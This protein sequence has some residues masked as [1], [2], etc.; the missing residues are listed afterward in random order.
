MIHNHDRS[1]WFGAS[2]TERVMGRWTGKTFDAWWH[3]KLGEPRK[4]I[5]TAAMRAGNEY[6]PR[7]LDAI[8]VE[9]RDGQILNRDLLLRVNL[10][11][12]DGDTIYEVK[13]VKRE[14]Q[15]VPKRIWMQCQVQMYIT[16]K[17]CVVVSYLMV[18]DDYVRANEID[19]RRLRYHRIP[20]DHGWVVSEYLPRLKRLSA[21]L[22]MHAWPK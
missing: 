17:K 5:E 13:T 4:R 8:G 9:R 22:K 21:A 20:Y 19:R 15:S 3:E 10:D 12:E 6:E 7:I 2:D 18:P 16:G 1:G 14:W 11:G